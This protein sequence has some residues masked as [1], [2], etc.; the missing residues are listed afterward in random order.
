MTAWHFARSDQVACRSA[1]AAALLT[2]TDRG[3]FPR[4]EVNAAL[5]D[6]RALF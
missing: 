2:L 3:W 1:S 5:L 4:R 6:V